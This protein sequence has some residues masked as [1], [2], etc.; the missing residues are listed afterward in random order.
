MRGRVPA[1]A[2]VLLG[3]VFLAGAA[4]QD[5]SPPDRADLLARGE[6]FIKRPGRG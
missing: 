4:T 5:A 6:A 1:V 2:G 3:G